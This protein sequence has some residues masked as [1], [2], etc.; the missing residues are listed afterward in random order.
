MDY[1]FLAENLL[2]DSKLGCC[3]EPGR[4]TEPVLEMSLKRARELGLDF[5]RHADLNG[6]G[7]VN[8]T[9][10]QAYTQHGLTA[11]PSKVKRAR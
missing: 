3:A 11:L 2:A 4:G 8:L 7:V 1:A 6:D 10:M 5:M 9:D